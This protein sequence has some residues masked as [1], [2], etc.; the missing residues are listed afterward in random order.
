MWPLAVITFKEGLRT[1]VFQALSV[2]AVC[3]FLLTA[4]FS[5]FFAR[6]VVKVSIDLSL[7]GMMFSGLLFTLFVGSSLIAKDLDR[8]TIH[9]VLSKAISRPTYIVGKFV[10]FAL[11]ITVAMFAL[12]CLASLSVWYVDQITSDLYGVGTWAGFLAAIL[13]GILMLILLASV[14]FFF[15]SF[16]SNSLLG[17]GLTVMVYYIGQSIEQVK[18]F[19]LTAETGSQIPSLVNHVVVGASYLFPNFAAFDSS[20][21]L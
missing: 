12:G 6:D 17:L 18:L 16:Q 21:R 7:S 3:L 2:L 14:G 13:M 9:T 5:S 4:V 10:G 8:R 15:A 11:L 1:R 20:F 19:L